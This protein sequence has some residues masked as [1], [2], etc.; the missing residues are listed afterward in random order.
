MFLNYIKNT[1]ETAYPD[2]ITQA[3]GGVTIFMSNLKAT[4]SF[5]WKF[6]GLNFYICYTALSYFFLITACQHRRI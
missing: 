4:L 5:Y 2:S 1:Y 3:G 6:V